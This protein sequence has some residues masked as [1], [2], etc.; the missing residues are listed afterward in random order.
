MLYGL[1]ERCPPWQGPLL[2]A[3]LQQSLHHRWVCKCARVSQLILLPATALVSQAGG[4]RHSR[5]LQP[6]TYACATVTQKA[7]QVQKVVLIEKH[8]W[9]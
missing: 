2:T 8:Q 4:G 9:W 5:H 6:G 7:V 3:H 1:C